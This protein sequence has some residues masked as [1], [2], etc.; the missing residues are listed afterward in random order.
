[1]KIAILVEGYTE[2]AFKPHLRQFLQARLANQMPKLLIVRCD[3]RIPKGN[4]LKR[5]VEK[6]L[7]GKKAVHAVIALTDVYTGTDDFIDAADAK[8]KMRNWVDNHPDFYPHTAQHDFEAWLLPFWSDIQKLA[9][10]NKK[11]PGK[12]PEKVNHNKAPAKHIEEIFRLGKRRHYNKPRDAKAILEGKDLM[13]SV[14]ACP[15]LKAFLNTILRLCGG[16]DIP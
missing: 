11:A 13:I 3:G 8:Q 9:G 6:L 16:T 15:E 10:H 5:R 7:Q 12:E 2:D 1:M 14:N 4:E